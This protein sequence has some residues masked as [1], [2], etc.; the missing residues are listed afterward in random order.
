[1]AVR[2]YSVTEVE[3][4]YG[5]AHLIVWSGILNGD[6]GT[7]YSMP[8]SADRSVQ[9][10]GTFGVGGSVTMQVSN[11]N[12]PV[13]TSVAQFV[14]AHDPQGSALTITAAGIKEVAEVSYWIRPNC[15]AGDGTTSL[16]VAMMVRKVG[17]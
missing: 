13:D 8:T 1:M 16:T 15:T 2:A 7:P 12:Q 4:L 14:T 9:V 6:T 10:Y 3:S 17:L 5:H 11:E